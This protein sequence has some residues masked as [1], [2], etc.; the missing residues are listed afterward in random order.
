VKGKTSAPARSDHECVKVDFHRTTGVDPIPATKRIIASF[1]E[2]GLASNGDGGNWS[3]YPVGEN[4]EVIR[5]VF[6]RI[7]RRNPGDKQG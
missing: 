6:L 4:G 3:E 5:A 7:Q 2:P 1:M